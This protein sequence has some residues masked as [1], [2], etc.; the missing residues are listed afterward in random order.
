MYPVLKRSES[1]KIWKFLSRL[2]LFVLKLWIDADYA[3]FYPR[4]C[5]VTRYNWRDVKQTRITV[6][7]AEIAVSRSSAWAARVH[8][9]ILRNRSIPNRIRISVKNAPIT[10]KAKVSF[11]I[12]LSSL[13]SSWFFHFCVNVS[14]SPELCCDADNVKTLIENLNMAESIFGRCPTCLKN[15]YKL[16]CDLVCSPEQSKFLR[17]TKTGNN[18]TTES[19]KRKEY[20]EE[21]EVRDILISLC[22]FQSWITYIVF[23][24]FFFLFFKGLRR[25]GIHEQ[26]LRFLQIRG[27]ASEWEISYGSGLRNLRR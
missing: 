5:C 17:V 22:F 23:D 20:V 25:R 11:L 19:G 21:I 27:H 14:D 15:V 12:D 3:S 10:L 6:Y 1:L 7:G 8:R 24:S 13:R 26:N 18:Y 9:T 16:L 2:R 4:S